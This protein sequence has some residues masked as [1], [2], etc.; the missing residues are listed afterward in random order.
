MMVNK[1]MQKGAGVAVGD[2]VK[3]VVEVDTATRVVEVPEELQKA[4]SKSKKARKT[5][6]RI[7][8]SHKKEYVDYIK[9]AKKPETRAKRVQKTVEMLEGKSES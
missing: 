6:E 9:E 2:K 8:Y 1:Q 5:F 4:L 3:V 7:P